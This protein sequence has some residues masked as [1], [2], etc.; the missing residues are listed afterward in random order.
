MQ[1]TT[2]S[3]K[4]MKSLALVTNNRNYNRKNFNNNQIHFSIER[5]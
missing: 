2:K 4:N 1:K 5:P 3:K